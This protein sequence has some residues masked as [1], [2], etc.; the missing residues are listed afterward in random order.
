MLKPAFKKVTTLK[1]K[2]DFILANEHSFINKYFKSAGQKACVKCT[3]QFGIT[4]VI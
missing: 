2:T 3:D 4:S 1:R